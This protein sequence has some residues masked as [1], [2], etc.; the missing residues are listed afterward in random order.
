MASEPMIERCEPCGS[1]TV[2]S[3]WAAFNNLFPPGPFTFHVSGKVQVGNLG[4]D[5]MLVERVPQGT[6]PN[7]L[8]MDLYLCQRPGIWPQLVV[9]KPV[10]YTQPIIDQRY[11]QVDI[12]CGDTRLT[13]IDVK[14][15]S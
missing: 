13:I 3:D 4:V 8:I 6:N 9:T 10:H 11:S 12:Y 2:S 15:I 14:D 5:P 1:G 7:I